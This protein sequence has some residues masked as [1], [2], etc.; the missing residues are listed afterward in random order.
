[1][2]GQDQDDWNSNQHAMDDQEHLLSCLA[3]CVSHYLLVVTFLSA[4]QL[5]VLPQSAESTLYMLTSLFSRDLLD[6]SATLI[7]FSQSF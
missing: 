4:D 3:L 2:A 5:A 1:M 7:W 6:P